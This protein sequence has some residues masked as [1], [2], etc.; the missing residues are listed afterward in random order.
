MARKQDYQIVPFPKMRRLTADIG[1]LARERYTIRGLMEIDVTLPRQMIQ[2]HQMRTGERLSFTAFLAACIGK[3]IAAN[4]YVQAYQNW[5]G[6]LV[7]FNDVDIVTLI[8]VEKDGL[9]YPVGHIVRGANRKSVADITTEIREVQTKSARSR[10][11]KSV[12]RYILIPGFIRRCFMRAINAS[13]Q[14]SKRIK[15]TVALAAV[16]MFDGRGGWGMGSL[17]HT[18]GIVVGGIAQKPGIVEGRIEARD[19][20]HL[21]LEFDHDMVDGAPAARFAQ[22]LC[23]LIESGCGLELIPG[24][25]PT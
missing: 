19:Y 9:K 4:P 13:P 15:G 16:G 12:E 17:S 20:L 11:S 22:H 8:E 21:T 23:E 1:V 10:E 6:Q 14:W 25:S 3:A 18:L 5:R 2:N 24:G 7:L